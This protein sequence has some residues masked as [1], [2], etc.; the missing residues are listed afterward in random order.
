MTVG[1]S[2]EL[3][4]VG[5]AAR[6]D[7]DAVHRAREVVL[8]ASRAAVRTSSL[9]IRAVHRHELDAA[10]RHLD[11]AALQLGEVDVASAAHPEVRYVGPFHDAQ[12][13]YVEARATLAF[14]AHEPL[15]AATTLGVSTPAY[16]NGLAEA[17]SEL[18][19]QV[20]DCLRRDDLAEAEALFEVMDD[21]YGLL[22]SIDFPDAITG[23]LRR[24][25]DALR[26]VLERTR[27]DLTHAV[28]SARPPRP[29]NG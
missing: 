5:I 14:V 10:R 23:G 26:A 24:S 2:S 18:R 21:V 29:E 12:K 22:Q 28:V 16:L 7:L 20:L 8:P 27:G 17:A 9:A 13:E 15:P 19:R 4:E 1:R 6:A 25:T 3:G 11:E